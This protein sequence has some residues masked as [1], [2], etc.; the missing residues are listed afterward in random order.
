MGL[1]NTLTHRQTD[2]HSPGGVPG[3]PVQLTAELN[4]LAHL[5]GDAPAPVPD[6]HH[7]PALLA[8]QA[9]AD[10]VPVPGVPDGVLQQIDDDLLD[11]NGLHGHK[12]NVVGHLHGDVIVGEPPSDGDQSV[13]RHLLQGLLLFVQG[14]DPVPDL[15]DGQQVLH[16]GDEGVGVAFDVPHQRGVLL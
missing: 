1:D 11:Q 10:V 14:H 3:Q 5:L 12:Q 7:R 9:Q 13:A 16:H 2:S 6:L 8:E 15:G 4:G